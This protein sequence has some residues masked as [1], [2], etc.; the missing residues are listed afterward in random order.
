MRSILGQFLEHSRA[1]EFAN[2]GAPEV[3]IGSADLMHRNLDRRVE[4][5]VSLAAPSHVETINEMFDL[6]FD[7]GTAAWDLD[8]E[9]VWHRRAGNAD[10]AMLADIQHFM[11]KNVNRR[12]G[13]R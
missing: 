5:L 13:I 7:P 9:G 8:A 10:D 1:Y 6:A 3:W 4:T 11:I 12:G 2:A